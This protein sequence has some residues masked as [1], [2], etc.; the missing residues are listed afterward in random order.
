MSVFSKKSINN[1]DTMTHLHYWYV[2]CYVYYK[3]NIYYEK[4]T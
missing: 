3:T 2:F 4:F 1:T